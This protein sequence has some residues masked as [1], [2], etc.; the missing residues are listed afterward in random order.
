MQIIENS[1]IKEKM[2]IE[3][4]ENGLTVMIIPKKGVQKKYITWGVNFGSVDNK[5]LI[6]NSSEVTNIPDGIAHYLEHK[7]FEQR[8]GINS[9]DVLSSLGVDANAYT[10][11]N[12]TAYLYECTDN[13]FEALDEFM[14]YVQNPYYTAEN[15]EKERGIIEQEIAM[16]DDEPDWAMYMNALKLMYHNNPIRID[17][18][19]TKESIAKINEKTLYTIYNNFYVPENMAI[20]VCGDFEPESILEEIKK[21][22][23]IKN[24]NQKITRVYSE[25]PDEIKEKFKEIK[26][27]ISM[28]IFT[29]GYKLKMTN[30]N[31]VKKDL[32]IE[33]LSGIILGASSKLYKRLYEEG[34]ILSEFGFD[35]EFARD[36][37]HIIIQG[38]S[39]N[40]EKVIEEIKNEMEFFINQGISE[41]E[42]ERQ[43]KNVYGEYV[44]RYNDV[45]TIGNMAISNYFKGINMFLYFEEF[46]TLTKEYLEEVL[47]SSFKEE[48][49][50]V[51]IVKGL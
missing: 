47:R 3:K 42:F 34:L 43:K 8:T 26:M 38:T 36:Y 40:P 4:L 46:D 37:S 9:L 5:F 33:I 21:R 7:M 14:D 19:G 30:E 28:P 16:Y 45:S 13:F 44:K 32:A 17:I 15:V 31:M 41:E 35:F 1:K 6:G 24:S 23:I 50:V 11:N 49:K 20:A 39:K 12:Y 25:E 18:A 22:M 27:P 48:N 2:Y 51:S 10:T 29:I